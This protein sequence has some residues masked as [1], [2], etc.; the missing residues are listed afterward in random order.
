MLN[1]YYN[2]LDD[3]RKEYEK[4]N[5]KNPCDADKLIEIIQEVNSTYDKIKNNKDWFKRELIP[6]LMQ[7]RTVTSPLNAE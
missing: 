1:K 4:E 3:I 6:W 5:S 7:P 2:K